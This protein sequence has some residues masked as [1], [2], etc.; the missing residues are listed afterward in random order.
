MKQKAFSRPIVRR[1]SKGSSKANEAGNF[2]KGG[3]SSSGLLQPITDSLENELMVIDRDYRII[4]ANNAVLL[5]HGKRRE[6]VIGRYCYDIS[7]GVFERCH[8]PHHRC[9]IEAVW[10]TGKV[11]RAAHLHVYHTHGDRQE[12]Y[13]DIIVSPIMDSQGNVIA[14][15]EL[16]CDVTEAKEFELKIAESMELIDAKVA[17]SRLLALNT[18]A[19][20]VSQSLDLDTVLSSA[21]DKTLEIMKANIG[22]IL[23]WDEERQML[24]YRVHR[25]LSARY[26]KEMCL[27]LGEGIAGKVAQTGEAI[28]LEDISMDSRAARLGLIA[29]EDLKSF[30]SIPLCSKEKVL[31]VINI[32]SR[33]ARKFSADDVRL[34]NSIAAQIAVAV[35]N[36]KLHQEVQH[37]EEIRGELLREI[38]SI[39]EEERRRIARELHDETSQVLASLTANLEAAASILPAGANK[40][41]ALLRKAQALSTNILDEIHRLI[42][43][44]RPTLLDDLGLVA[45]TRWL[46]DNNLV[47]AGVTVNFKTVGR[48]RRLP[49]QLET[50]LFRVAQ[51]AVFNI[52]RHAHA[53]NV[54]V[55]Q[56]FRKGSIRIHIKDDGRGFDVKEAVSSKDRP[57]GLGLLGMK[58]RVELMNGTLS[59]R[60]HPGGGGTEIDIEIPMNYGGSSG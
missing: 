48:E 49:P 23:L 19:S 43:E 12:R 34:L 44:L 45:A 54:S 18:I 42:Y 16:V 39:Q 21:L 15:A 28:L 14:V 51:E 3:G 35:E 25:G 26:A 31:G 13:V 52:T 8:P 41:R 37:K 11:A 53:K 47:A 40:T 5:R 6:E 58:E 2:V 59:I 29:S 4:E 10:K 57:R 50:T 1:R 30:A 32:V 56:H 24:C 46:V 9:P 27:R 36:A 38:F 17:Q 7:H 22:G 60:S 33:E 20:V 55:N